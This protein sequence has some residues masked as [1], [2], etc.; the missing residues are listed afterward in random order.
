MPQ[1]KAGIPEGCVI[2]PFARSGANELKATT[3]AALVAV[4]I[5]HDENISAEERLIEII[6]TSGEA[7]VLDTEDALA[8]LG[9]EDEGTEAKD[10]DYAANDNTMM[11]VI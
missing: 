6:E 11:T 4:T 9:L 5:V 7:E 3:L 2:L 1:N 10:G 8:E